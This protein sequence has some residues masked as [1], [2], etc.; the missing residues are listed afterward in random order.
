MF[1]TLLESRTQRTRRTRSTAASVFMH[2]A[3]IAI[4]VAMT[5]ATP[6]DAREEPV[7]KVPVWIDVVR[8]SQTQL[9]RAA[10]DA[11]PHHMPELPRVNPPT[12]VPNDLPPIDVGG[13]AIPDDRLLIGNAVSGPPLSSGPIGGPSDDRIVDEKLVDRAPRMLGDAQPPLY[14]PSLRQR[15]IT[16]Q[17]V[18]Q[19]VVDTLGRAEM[20]DVQIV[21]ASHVL[22]ADAVRSA[23]ARYRFTAGEAAGHRVR[24]RV[25]LPF[26]FSLR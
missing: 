21:E 5:R 6:S 7:E 11:A 9:P 25:Q 12:F 4:A 1:T 15:G 3:A 13:P 17:V 22:L 23:L 24:T 19:F 2:S 8:T 26:T 14:P 10:H 20:G 16:G 18:V